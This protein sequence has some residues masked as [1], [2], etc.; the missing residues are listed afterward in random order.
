VLRGVLTE[1]RLSHA[2]GQQRRQIDIGDRRRARER[3]SLGL[4]QQLAAVRHQ[5]V[6]V[7]P[8][9][10]S[11]EARRAVHGGRRFFAADMRTSRDSP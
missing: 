3:E 7:M 6:D 5:P 8:G 4:R 1:G 10:A 11:P 2:V 9:R